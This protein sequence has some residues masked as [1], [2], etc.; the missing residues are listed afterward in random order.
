MSAE[1]GGKGKVELH[2]RQMHADAGSG[3]AAKG[4]QI[5]RQWMYAIR[6]LG[7]VQPPLRPKLEGFGE[8]GAVGMHVVCIHADRDAGRDFDV[9]AV[10]PDAEPIDPRKTLDGTI[11]KAQ[12]YTRVL[13]PA[14]FSVLRAK[15]RR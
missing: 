7:V 2:R 6:A 9:I 8:N 1:Q 11:A 12:G 13:I 10:L 4:N 14:V 5:V 15:L 3:P